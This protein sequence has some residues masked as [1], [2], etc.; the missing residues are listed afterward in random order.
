MQARYDLGEP[1][2]R[3]PEAEAVIVIAS[4][5]PAGRPAVVIA[6]P[7]AEAIHGNT[8]G[9]GLLRYARNDVE[10]AAYAFFLVSHRPGGR[11]F[12]RRACTE[13]VVPVQNGATGCT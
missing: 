4:F 8:R 5:A 9:S 10:L 6:R 1:K 2:H 3:L 12:A 13:R 7:E 11:T